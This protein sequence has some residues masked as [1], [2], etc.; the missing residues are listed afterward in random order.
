MYNLLHE[1]SLS[2]S[3]PGSK[4]RALAQAVSKKMGGM[5]QTFDANF[6]KSFLSGA[7]GKYLD[8][9]GSMMGV[10]RLGETSASI[11]RSQRVIKFHVETGTFGSINSGSSILITAGTLI[12]TDT[13]GTGITYRV[14]YAVYLPSD[15]SEYYVSAE[16][17]IPGSASNVGAGRL[18][19]HN[20]LNY[21]DVLNDTLKVTNEVDITAGSEI[22]TDI[23][24]RYRISKQTLAGET[25][26]RTAVRLAA[27]KVPGV[28]DVREIPYFHGIGTFD[29]LIKSI[30]PSVPD[31][32][33]DAVFE[34]VSKVTAWG[35]IPYVRGPEEIGMSFKFELTLKKRVTS[36]EQTSMKKAII[37]NLRLYVNNLDIG[38]S[39]I[40]NEAVQRVM[41]TSDN[42]KTLGTA[43]KPFKKMYVHIPSQLQDNKIRKT[44][45]GDFD[46]E[47]DEKLLIENTYAT[48]TPIM[49]TITNA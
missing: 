20:F 17:T 33:V 19:Y 4:A 9:L 43:G 23:N 7:T 39:F 8:Y 46:P 42:I 28:A 24:Y 48:T 11:S 40:V 35:N 27:L 16:A 2:R 14:P 37:N 31:G 29:L 22:E 15:Q 5:Y 21:T 32:L 44:L 30:S 13:A 34:A 49:I 3:S 10:P 36:D 6:A 45:K 47:P 12:G 18:I 1:T 38:E 25:A 26:N 41:E